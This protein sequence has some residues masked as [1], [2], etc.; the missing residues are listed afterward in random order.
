[1]NISVRQNEK[2]VNGNHQLEMDS[3]FIVATQKW[4]RT[5]KQKKKII[6]IERE[7]DRERER[8]KEKERRN[9][10]SKWG[11]KQYSNTERIRVSI[12][13]YGGVFNTESLAALSSSTTTIA[14]I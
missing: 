3:I 9:K 6:E 12:V 11:K 7:R 4:S 1:M 5:N 2:I 14:T 10:S 13:T 8:E